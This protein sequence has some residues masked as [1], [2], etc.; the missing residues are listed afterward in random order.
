MK[1]SWLLERWQSYAAK[2]AFLDESGA[3]HYHELVELWTKAQ[4]EL[5]N[6]KL[7]SAQGFALVGEFGPASTVWLLLLAQ[8]DHWV[9]PLVDGDPD[10]A[11]KLKVVPVQW[12]IRTRGAQWEIKS[13]A[14]A[15]TWSEAE[16]QAQH[17][18]QGLVLFSSGTSGRPKIMVQHFPSLLNRFAERR[19]NHLRT[20]VVLGFDHIGGINTLW[21][22]LASGSCLVLTPS[23]S[24][25]AVSDALVRHQVNVLPASP[26]LLNLLLVSE[27]LPAA[28]LRSL[29][30]ITYGTEPM[31]QSL[32]ERLHTALPWVRLLQTFGT[33][34]TGIVQ[35]ESVSPDSTFLKLTDPEVAWKVVE[36]ELWLKTPTQIHGYLGQDS[37]A[38]TSDGWFRTGDQVEVSA[39]GSFKILGRKGELINVGG[40]KLMP[41]EVENVLLEEPLIMDCRVYGAPNFLTGQTVVADVVVAGDHDME[42][43]R[44]KLRQRCRQKLPRYKVPTQINFVS[45]VS[46]ARF[47][48]L[49]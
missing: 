44:A 8:H 27:C 38:F 47:K 48:K 11:E 41:L 22:G 21:G 23:R 3:Y 15:V 32:L 35:T 37:D 28:S 26:T 40:E 43:L 20:L 45:T 7:K 5:Q 16:L 1:N 14:P 19:E 17:L 36:G 9:L 4:S 30:L 29:R 46:G 34:E 2:P 31:P 6:L 42:D 39:D 12:V 18:P 10:F 25:A 24:P 33:T 49:R 13:V